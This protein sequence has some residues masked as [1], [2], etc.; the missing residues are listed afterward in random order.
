MTTKKYRGK[1]WT[2]ISSPA[3]KTTA[4]GILEH[5]RKYSGDECIFAIMKD[6]HKITGK[7][8]HR[9]LKRYRKR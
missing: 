7:T 6:T 8:V 4:R 2:V 9:V 3:S 1:Y 5:E